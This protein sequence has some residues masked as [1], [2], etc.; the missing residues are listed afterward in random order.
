VNFDDYNNYKTFA[1][2][3]A[4]WNQ[5]LNKNVRVSSEVVKLTPVEC[6]LQEFALGNILWELTFYGFSSSEVDEKSHELTELSNDT[7]S[8]TEVDVNTFLQDT[9]E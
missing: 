1:M 5:L 7:E 6:T 8:L 9:N 4:P 2:D 3:F